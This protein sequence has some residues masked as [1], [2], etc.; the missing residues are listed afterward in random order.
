MENISIKV[1]VRDNVLAVTFIILALGAIGHVANQWWGVL[2]PTGFILAG[3][4]SFTASLMTEWRRDTYVPLPFS[5]GLV[6]VGTGVLLTVLMAL[7]ATPPPFI[8]NTI[9]GW[10]N[11][12]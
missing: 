11:H 5:L 6:L 12:C 1:L 2:V 4:A 10:F 8:W 9:S 3:A 7:E